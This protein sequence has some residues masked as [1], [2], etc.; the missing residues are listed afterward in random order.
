MKR[1]KQKVELGERGDCSC[2]SN[3]NQDVCHRKQH[4]S[5]KA[6]KRATLL[7]S[8]LFTKTI[9]FL[10]ITLLQW[11][12]RGWGWWSNEWKAALCC[13]V[14]PTWWSITEL[15]QIK[16]PMM[17]SSLRLFN[18][19]QSPWISTLCRGMSNSFQLMPS[20]KKTTELQNNSP[21][22]QY[23]CQY[24]NCPLLGITFRGS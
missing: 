2:L 23:M 16:Q 7:L 12:R 4:L 22:L 3:G 20:S 10:L 18:A 6:A 9:F 21:L 5:V 11:K 1:S 17:S 8:K 13:C 19:F 24:S 14:D 15:R